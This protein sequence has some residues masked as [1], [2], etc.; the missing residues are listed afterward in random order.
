MEWIRFLLAAVLLCFGVATVCIAT[1]GIFKF[2]YVLNRMHAAA[3]CDTFALMLCMLGVA[4]LHGLSFT[5]LKLILIIVFLWFAS[6]VASHLIAR[7]EVTTNPEGLKKE[8][9]V[10]E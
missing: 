8:C 3:M 2:K 10:E 5:T 7:L 9:E 1:Y 6:P 4:V